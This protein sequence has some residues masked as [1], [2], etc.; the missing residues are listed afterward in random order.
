VPSPTRLIAVLVLQVLSNPH[1]K[2]VLF[3]IDE[4]RTVDSPT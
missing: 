4:S 1:S 2:R 3:A